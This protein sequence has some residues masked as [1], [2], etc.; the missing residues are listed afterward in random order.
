MRI[1]T[2]ALAAA[3]CTAVA[4]PVVAQTTMASPAAMPS[5]MSSSMPSAMSSAMPGMMMA[6]PAIE[7]T[8]IPRPPKPNFSSMKYFLGDW[9]CSIK[10]ARRPTPTLSTMHV[11]LDPTGYW[12]K[13]TANIKGTS[14]F[15]YPNIATDWFTYDADAHR[16]VDLETDT[17]GGYDLSYSPGW[18]GDT[19]VWTDIAFTPTTK[20]ASVS[21]TTIAKAGAKK[22]TIESSF[23]TG[24]GRVVGVKG[25][26]TRV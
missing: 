1:V 16:W 22:F 11:A 9:S 15:P 24:K 13:Q 18:K 14:W 21:T 5:A 23:T 10:S 17:V 7:A 25:A 20:I 19:L 26:C 2:A 6:A 3:I 4:L 8:P 12:M